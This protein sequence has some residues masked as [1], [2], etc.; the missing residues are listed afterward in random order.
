[1]FDCV[2]VE[3]ERLTCATTNSAITMSAQFD[4]LVKKMLAVK[5]KTEEAK[6]RELDAKQQLKTLKLEIFAKGNEADGYKRRIQL[7]SQKLKDVNIEMA[8]KE[9]TLRELTEKAELEGERGKALTHAEVETD[10]HLR[11]IET[12][13]QDAQSTA[14]NAQM[15]LNDAQRKLTVVENELSRSE[16]RRDIA[17]KRI[18]ELEQM[19]KVAGEDLRKL[20]QG[21][22][23]ASE[24]ETDFEKKVQLLEEEL[25]T[26]TKECEESERTANKSLRRINELM[27]EIENWQEKKQKLQDEIFAINELE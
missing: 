23:L 8:D 13:V 2:L 7:L 5:D 27:A 10:E 21:D 16:N 20:E 12:Q 15:R 1:M 18:P 24:R 17:Y 4:S 26:K 19:I 11:S 25:A 22:V 6:E 14:E 3:K 9:S